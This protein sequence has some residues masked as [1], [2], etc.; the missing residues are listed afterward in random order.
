MTEY[1]RNDEKI[2]FNL[3]SLYERYGYSQYKMTK[4]EEYD[5]YVRNKDFLSSK[6]IITFTDTN[7]RLLALKPDVTLSIIKNNRNNHN[8]LQKVYYNEN[9]YRVSK[10]SDSFKEIMQAG[11]ECI[12]DVDCY[13]L[14]EVLSLAAKSLKS[15]SSDSVLCVSDIDIISG[16]IDSVQISSEVRHGILRLIGEKNTHEL[17]A[18]CTENNIDSQ[19]LELLIQ[20]TGI[21]GNTDDVLPKI[22]QLLPDITEVLKFEK[23]LCSLTDEI[24]SMIEIDF[25]VMGDTKYYNGI[26]FRG[27][28]S[29][30]PESVLSGGQYDKLMSKMNQNT[31]AVGFAVYLDLLERLNEEYAEY[32]VDTVLLYDENDNMHALN[33]AIE[34]LSESSA[35][36]AVKEIPE[37]IKFRQLMKFDGRE[38][39]I[40]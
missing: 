5:L 8:R 29:S 26:V 24:K 10:G 16:V 19:T 13:C 34:K 35:V 7:G 15:I 33:E 21:H 4:F 37:K 11:L 30:V 36:L 9:V 2:I 25:S 6:N 31:G 39:E 22:K 1:I 32:D 28:I 40:I 14:G 27:F 12:G 18:L 17:Y 38:A 20:L 3:R 23:I